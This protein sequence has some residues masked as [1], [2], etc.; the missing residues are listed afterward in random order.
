MLDNAWWWQA[1]LVAFGG[2]CGAIA[3]YYVSIK[4]NKRFPGSIPYGTLTVN[5]AGSFLLG[6]ILGA[7]SRTL[8]LLLGTGFM[9]A[10]TTFSTLK[11]EGVMLALNSQWR[12]LIIYYGLSYSMGIL[13]AYFGY[14]LVT[15]AP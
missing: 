2:F 8:T 7:N 12:A 6:M 11:I 1:G 9:G 13:L 5:L 14:V 15:G 4:M 3:R 10:F